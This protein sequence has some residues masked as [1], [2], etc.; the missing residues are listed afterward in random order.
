MNRIKKWL[1]NE[2]YEITGFPREMITLE[3]DLFALV[4]SQINPSPF[5]AARGF[6]NSLDME[7]PNLPLRSIY[8]KSDYAKT[9]VKEIL[10]YLLNKNCPHELIIDKEKILTRKLIHQPIDKSYIPPPA[11]C[12]N[13]SSVLVLTGGGNGITA[14]TGVMLAEKY[15]CKIIALGRTRLLPNEPYPGIDTESGIKE[16]IFEKLKKKQP[17]IP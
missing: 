2:I 1:A 5:Y 7:W 16:K 14:E 12:L 3:G 6:F 11:V 10:G 17:Q 15:R 13:S 9:P 4:G 8:L